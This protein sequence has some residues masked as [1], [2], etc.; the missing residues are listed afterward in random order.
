MADSRILEVLIASDDHRM[1]SANA[2]AWWLVQNDVFVPFESFLTDDSKQDFLRHLE[3][4]DTEWF[5]SFFSREPE[6]AYLTRIEPDPSVRGSEAMIR[7]VLNR[8]DSL[9]EEYLRQGDGLDSYDT[10]LSFYEDDAAIVGMPFREERN[11]RIFYRTVIFYITRLINES[12]RFGH[13]HALK[14]ESILSRNHIGLDDGVGHV[15]K[16][17]F[18]LALGEMRNIA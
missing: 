7:V 16:D 3:A 6:A 4:S 11:S 1:L 17:T 15:R 12:H 2:E 8:L 18:L 10:M 5:L 14:R 13:T 9:M